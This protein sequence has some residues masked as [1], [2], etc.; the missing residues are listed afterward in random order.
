MPSLR[1]ARDFLF[2]AFL[3]CFSAR[4]QQPTQPTAASAVT[5]WHTS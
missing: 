2:I 5:R 1:H 3:S 4:A